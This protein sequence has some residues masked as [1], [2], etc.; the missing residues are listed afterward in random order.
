MRLNF[1]PPGDILL[2]KESIALKAKNR[3][4]IRSQWREFEFIFIS[5]R[6]AIVPPVKID[7]IIKNWPVIRN[8]LA[9]HHRKCRLQIESLSQIFC[10]S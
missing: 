10:V 9:E 4:K 5:V 2:E 7:H 3:G 6:N 1:F 8:N